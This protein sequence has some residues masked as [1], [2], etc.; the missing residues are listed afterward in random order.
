MRARLTKDFTFEAAQTLPN[1]PEGHKC[2]LMHGHS[3]KVE[4]SVEGEVDPHLGWVYDHA[5]ISDAIKPL[6]EKLDHGYL[7]EIEG[8]A[9]PTI[10]NMAAWLWQRLTPQCPGLCEIVIHETPTARCIYRGE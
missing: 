4:V 5:R 10:E 3:F 1:A 6:L 9:N 2:R 8:L 7:N